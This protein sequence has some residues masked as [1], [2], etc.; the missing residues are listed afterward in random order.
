MDGY[1][2]GSPLHKYFKPKKQTTWQDFLPEAKRRVEAKKAEY[3]NIDARMMAK[4]I[5]GYGW[6]DANWW[7]MVK[8]LQNGESV[9][10]KN[11][12]IAAELRKDCSGPRFSDH[13]DGWTGGY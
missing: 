9:K 12:Q 10:V 1:P 2:P 11:L 6:K 8:R 4:K 13:G 3:G 5:P 7:K